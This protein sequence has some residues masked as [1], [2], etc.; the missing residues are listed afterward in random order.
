MSALKTLFCKWHNQNDRLNWQTYLLYMV[1]VFFYKR[2]VFLWVPT[3]LPHL[4]DLSF[5]PISKL[6]SATSQEQWNDSF[7]NYG[8]RIYPFELAI[9]VTIVTARSSSS[10]DLFLII[11]LEDQLRKKQL[12][13]RGDDFDLPFLNSFYLYIA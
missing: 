2:L 6:H 13:H 8:D 5:I 12:Y 7:N 3:V 11:D 9:S 4:A 1:N 10:F